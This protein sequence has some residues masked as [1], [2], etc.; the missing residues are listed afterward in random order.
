[1]QDVVI[2]SKRSFFLF[3]NLHIVITAR[4]EAK[5]LTATQVMRCTKVSK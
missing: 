3:S 4:R 5:Y 1:M 2:L